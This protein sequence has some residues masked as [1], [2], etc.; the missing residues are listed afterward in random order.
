MARKRNPENDLVVTSSAAATR[1]RR[2]T[3][4]ARPKHSPTTADTPEAPVL[5]S[6]KETPAAASTSERK[7]SHEEISAL[8]HSYWLARGCQGGSPEEDWR[9]AEEELRLQALVASN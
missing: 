9:R 7:L 8:A 1:A 5:K 4:A 6:E 3:S 2:T